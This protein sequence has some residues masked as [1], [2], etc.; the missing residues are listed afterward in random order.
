MGF[1]RVR[2]NNFRNIEPRE[3]KWCPGLN[4]LTGN[5][6]SGKTNILE[7][8]NIISGWGPLER[9]T[10]TASLP[11]WNSGSNEVQLTGQLEG[12]NGEIIK[13]KISDRYSIKFEEKQIRAP[14]LRWKVPVLSFLP[15]DVAIIESSAS[16]RRRLL[17]MILALL[18]PP[19]AVRLNDY[20]RGIKQKAIILRRGESTDIINRALMPLALWIWKMREECILLLSEC[21]NNVDFAASSHVDLFLKRGGAG[22]LESPEDDYLNAISANEERESVI[23]IPLVGPHRDDLV[24]NVDNCRA[25]SE[26]LSRG[27]RRR[28]AIALILAASDGVYRKLGKEPILLLD[29]VTAELDPEGKE[30]LF[31]SLIKRKAQ[32]FAATAEPYAGVFPGSTYD[33]NAGRVE[34]INEYQ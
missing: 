16:Y 18:I 25:A 7:G 21:I 13:V 23:K 3:M 15:N 1:C 6:G 24:I 9:G 31:K 19:Y 33:I 17:D 30:V 11:T 22:V 14:E 4:L 34:K 26:S 10:K 2:F 29:E 8:I 28:I 32:V 12:D 5:N 27:Y 20:R